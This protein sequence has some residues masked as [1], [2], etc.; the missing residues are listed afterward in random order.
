MEGVRASLESKPVSNIP[1]PISRSEDMEGVRASL[2]SKPVSNIPVPI[3]RSE[4]MEGVRAS[5][6]SS[7][8]TNV[9]KTDILNNMS[10]ENEELKRKSV[11]PIIAPPIVANNIQ[12]TNTQTLTPIKAQ[13][14]GSTSSAL[15]KYM[16]RNLVY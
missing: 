1:V 11:A 15:E 14:R 9:E 16:E 6:E 8:K 3:S 13:P 4:D 7:F 5:L 2:E 10:V 12:S